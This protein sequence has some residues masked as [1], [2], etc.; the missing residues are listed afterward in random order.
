MSELKKVN[1]SDYPS[2]AAAMDSIP[3]NLV[4]SDTHYEIYLTET[5][6]I[7]DGW[8]CNNKNILLDDEGN[9]YIKLE[10]SE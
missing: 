8:S 7:S 9:E 2:L 10:K 6:K 1:V 4:E 5:D 3:K